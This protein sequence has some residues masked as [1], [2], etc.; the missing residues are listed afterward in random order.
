MAEYIDKVQAMNIIASGKNDNAYFGTTDK[1][2]E[3]ID[4]LK[5]VPTANVVEISEG[6]TN[7]DMIKAMFP[8]AIIEINELG[9]MVHVKYNNHTCWV[10][11][12]LDWWNAPYK[13]EVEE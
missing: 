11:Y 7:G 5:T 6:A 13:R 12:E 9:S 1:D 2:W 8:N 4:F 10:N 3:V